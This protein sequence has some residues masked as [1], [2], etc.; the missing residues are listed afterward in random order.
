MMDR[1]LWTYLM[2]M[3]IWGLAACAEQLEM[4]FVRPAE[5]TVGR[6]PAAEMDGCFRPERY[7]LVSNLLFQNTGA[8]HIGARDSAW[9]FSW[10]GE[11]IVCAIRT[12]SE[13]ELRA[14][15]NE[16]DGELWN[17]DS[18]EVFLTD[19]SGK[20]GCHFIFNSKSGMY[21]AKITN[22]REN[23]SWNS[24]KIQWKTRSEN[25]YW[26]LEAAIPLAETGI[27][28][29]NGKLKATM[30]RAGGKSH[31]E[32]IGQIKDAFLDPSVFVVLELVQEPL[33]L[34]IR[35]DVQSFETRNLEL[36]L[37]GNASKS[38]ELHGEV[39][40]AKLDYGTNDAYNQAEAKLLY[41]MDAAPGEAFSLKL[42][43][44]EMP[45]AGTLQYLVMSGEKT[46]FQRQMTFDFAEFFKFNVASIYFD[47]LR[48][49]LV[50][51]VF[52]PN[53]RNAID[54]VYGLRD[55]NG[56]EL[57]RQA[58]SVQGNAALQIP[59]KGIAPGEYRYFVKAGQTEIG[60][61]VAILPERPEWLGNQLGMT[62]GKA[63]TPW[64]DIRIEK[65]MAYVWNRSI[66]FDG[67]PVHFMSG[68]GCVATD[69]RFEAA[70]HPMKLEQ[71]SWGKIAGDESEF[72]GRFSFKGGV[73]NVTGTL[74]FDGLVTINSE[75][76]PEK[77]MPLPDIECIMKVPEHNG[78]FVYTSEHQSHNSQQLAPGDSWS[79]NMLLD[80]ATFWIGSVKRGIYFL[81]DDLRGWNLSDYSKSVT[82]GPEVKGVRTVRI[83]ILER[84]LNAPS[85]VRR[86]CFTLQG[87][88][89]RPMPKGWRSYRMDGSRPQDCNI[90]S[91]VI[92][93]NTLF[94]IPMP[95]TARAHN[96]ME[97]CRLAHQK[98]L[99]YLSILASSQHTDEYRFFSEQWRLEPQKRPPCQPVQYWSYTYVCPQGEGYSDYY[100]WQLKK[101]IDALDAHG[102][103][104]DFAQPGVYLC[105][106]Q[107]HGCGWKDSQGNLRSS[108]RLKASRDLMKRIYVI[109]KEKDPDSVICLHNSGGMIPAFHC[110][111]EM[112]L[113]GEQAAL[114]MFRNGVSYSGLYEPDK[115][116]LEQNGEIWGVPAFYI[117]QYL[118]VLQLWDANRYGDY[119]KNGYDGLLKG[120]YAEPDG[121]K[122]I[123]YLAGM[124]LVHGGDFAS[125]G[126]AGSIFLKVCGIRD[127]FKW[128]DQVKLWGWY[129]DGNPWKLSVP[130]S[131]KHLL[132][133]YEA[134][135]GWL[136]VGMN[137]TKQ[138]A[139]FSIRIPEPCAG[140][141]FTDCL[142]D[143]EVIP[144]G[145]VLELHL[146]DESPR[147]IEVKSK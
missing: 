119:S 105:A 5:F 78:Q 9:A 64:S 14:D 103:Y 128:N 137:D 1:R 113:N 132:S 84:T 30:I 77:G 54:C 8:R 22:A 46:V 26:T 142:S 88:P 3:A 68:E 121:A 90:K 21:D 133:A 144:N 85:E 12:P 43:G 27:S 143:E 81:A 47:E 55:M 100:V 25:G 49:N 86:I 45:E 94:N 104:F 56:V 127:R 74:E 72:T 70:G 33:R 67:I 18:Y 95:L 10:D 57:C 16:R 134:E 147:F 58:K 29:E 131:N 69:L 123:W 2:L 76:V 48:E 140:W 125:D 11:R 19:M 40:V 36:T 141:T 120:F 23:S 71:F 38:Q 97:S 7:S 62:N 92:D 31:D 136:L 130:K 4:G 73:M 63:P 139:V 6:M 44:K 28:L 24:E 87:T 75:F 111:S 17:D 60:D 138:H 112:T 13:G 89:T 53:S 126:G 80:K 91:G 106:N 83:P 118:R 20:T 135:D 52:F 145:D 51:E 107:Y 79:K 93:L 117:P 35:T 61:R 66:R 116:M 101:M 39:R 65:N 122:R 15:N 32:G 41:E 96:E 82:V 108:L 98:A 146:D 129:D 110:F 102:L 124:L 50:L 114:D 99:P 59:V 34:D 109:M 115:L 42:S 37:A